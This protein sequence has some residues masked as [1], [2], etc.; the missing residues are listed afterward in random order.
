MAVATIPEP[1]T[2]ILPSLAFIS[3][4]AFKRRGQAKRAL[5]GTGVYAVRFFASTA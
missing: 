3:L 2:L 4:L 1:S 5:Y